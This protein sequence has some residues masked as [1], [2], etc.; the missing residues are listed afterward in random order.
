MDTPMQ[1]MPRVQ[2]QDLVTMCDKNMSVTFCLLS[3]FQYRHCS[4]DLPKFKCI[5]SDVGGMRAMVVLRV[6]SPMNTPMQALPRVRS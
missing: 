5:C 2:K 3:A 6:V 4:W 1:A